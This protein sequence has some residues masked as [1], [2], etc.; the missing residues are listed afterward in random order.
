LA[1][2]SY[3]LY[4]FHYPT[5]AVFDLLLPKANVISWT[6]FAYFVIRC[7]GCLFVTIVFYYMFERNTV[8]LRRYLKG[9][10]LRHA[11]SRYLAETPLPAP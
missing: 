6:T 3:T 7:G 1:G 5:L 8:A 4:L 2:F 11:A 9:S 10:V